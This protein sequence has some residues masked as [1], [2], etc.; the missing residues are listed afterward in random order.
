VDEFHYTKKYFS[1]SACEVR[2]FDDAYQEVK[3]AA[4]SRGK[5]IVGDC[6]SHPEW[7]AVLSP[8]DYREHIKAGYRIAG[9][10]SVKNGRTRLRFWVA[11]SALPLRVEYV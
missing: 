3:Q 6:H 1:Q 9:V 4:E 2:W 5:S 10:C 7:D 8:T 11:E